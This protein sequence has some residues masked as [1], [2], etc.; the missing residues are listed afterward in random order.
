MSKFS[1]LG[2]G[3][4]L[5]ASM[6][7]SGQKAK[8]IDFQRDVRPILSDACF[9]CHGP[10]KE[11]RMAKLR[12]DT[13]EGALARAIVPG[14]PL[15][16]R[17]YQRIMQPNSALRMPPASSHK[18]LS[19][20]QKNTLKAWIEQGAP[21]KEHWAFKA[22]EKAAVPAG[23]NAIDYFIQARLDVEGLTQNPEANR[24]ILARRLSLDLTG[25]PPAPAD[26]ETFLADKSPNAYEKL[27]EKFLASPR[28][29]EHRARYWLDAARY[30]DTHGIHVDNYREMWPYRDWLI[31]AFNSNMRFDQFTIEQ[32]AGD[33]LEKRTLDQQVASGFHRCGISTNEAG[34][35]VDEVEAIYAK[36]RVDTT[37]TVFLGLTLGCATCHDHKFDPLTQRDFY[38]MAAFFRNTTQ[39]TM[40]DNIPDTPPIVVV[41]KPE[42]SVRWSTLTS[43]L[44][45]IR[46]KRAS[47]R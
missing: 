16:S 19:D 6:S 30:A 12:L 7:V 22:P 23:R 34:I 26:V 10:D 40:D 39:N 2:A 4:V 46:A 45:D 1:F 20:E 47:H 33:L 18:V 41:P 44:R 25:L 38:S 21:W 43:E 3:L 37:G 32:I 35:I 11:S 15:E 8:G 42:D 17:L 5:A 31:R 36:D 14:K 24:R 9:H 29:G 27:V 28:Y 13:K